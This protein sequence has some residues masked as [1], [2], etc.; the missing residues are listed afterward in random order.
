MFDSHL[1]D[2]FDGVVATGRTPVWKTCGCSVK[3]LLM[4]RQEDFFCDRCR[5]RIRVRAGCGRAFVL[6][7]A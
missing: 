5:S 6:A 3:N 7:F 1:L 4:K 2:R